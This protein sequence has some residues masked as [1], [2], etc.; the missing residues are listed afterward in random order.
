[1]LVH[2]VQAF[3]DSPFCVRHAYFPWDCKPG[4]HSIASSCCS[5]A[6]SVERISKAKGSVARRQL[7]PRPVQA[8]DC[9]YRL[10]FPWD[11][12][13]CGASRSDECAALRGWKCQLRQNL[14]DG[15]GIYT[16]AG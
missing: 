6:S 12:C 5:K 4:M 3:L 11:P 8:P 2:I 13:A 10:A 9:F 16:S 14:Q 1:M 15:E 7:I